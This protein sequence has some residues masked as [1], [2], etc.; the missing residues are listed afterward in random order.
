MLQ[1]AIIAYVTIVIAQILA[2]VESVRSW[3]RENTTFNSDYSTNE[4]LQINSEAILQR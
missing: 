3:L 2:E 1:E 4:N